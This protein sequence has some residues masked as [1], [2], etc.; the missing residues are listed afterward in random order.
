MYGQMKS[1]YVL[2]QRDEIHLVTYFAIVILSLYSHKLTGRRTITYPLSRLIAIVVA[3][4]KILYRVIYR[5]LQENK[6]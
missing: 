4:A 6:Y 3:I 1:V 5:R 2:K